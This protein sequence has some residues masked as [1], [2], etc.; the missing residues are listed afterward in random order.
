MQRTL[1][2]QQLNKS[3]RARQVVFS[4]Y[5]LASESPCD[6]RLPLLSLLSLLLLSLLSMLAA[7][8]VIQASSMVKEAEKL[9]VKPT[10]SL[11]WKPDH[12]SAALL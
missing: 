2:L 5:F 8:V 4:S 9:L 7:G 12:R 3:R 11:F 6:P 1:R 10:F